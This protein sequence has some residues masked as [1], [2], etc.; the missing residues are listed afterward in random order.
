M[1]RHYSILIVVG[2]ILF[3]QLSKFLVDTFLTNSITVIPYVLNF[4]YVQNTGASFGMLQQYGHLLLWISVIIIG[5]LLYHFDSFE[6]NHL[7]WVGLIL[8]GAVGNLIDRLVHGYVIDFIDFRI[9]PVFNV[10]DS[11][12]TIGGLMLVWYW[13]RST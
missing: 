9:W 1:K 10:A 2:I 6:E 3:D 4:T 5:L 11:A 7:P 8:G 12:I 13:I